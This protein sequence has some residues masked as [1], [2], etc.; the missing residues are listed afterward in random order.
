M[1]YTPF[2]YCALT[3]IGIGI[4]G[5]LDAMQTV[6]LREELGLPYPDDGNGRMG[7]KLND[8]E[9]KRF[10]SYNTVHKLSMDYLPITTTMLLI[11]GIHYPIVSTVLGV[12]YIA[13]RQIFSIGY[14]ASGPEGRYNGNAILKIAVLGLF[15]TSAT[16]CLKM[17]DVIELN[18]Y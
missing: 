1:A 16:S 11:G 6:N 18:G 9:W 17:L 7:V 15:V 14:R 12:V 10:A 4:Q 13:G 3:A 5:F 8:T 2:G